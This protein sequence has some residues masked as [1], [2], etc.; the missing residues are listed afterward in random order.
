MITM[1]CMSSILT[2]T[3]IAV[4]GIPSV[5]ADYKAEP[6]EEQVYEADAV[7]IVSVVSRQ[8]STEK[9]R[10]QLL[11]LE[12]EDIEILECTCAVEDILGV[13]KIQLKKKQT[14]TILLKSPY[15]AQFEIDR[16]YALFLNK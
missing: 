5:R 9:D 10:R 11:Q 4:M 3:V 12:S 1:N 6:L 14:I 7:V 13:N 8:L 16:K 15:K 2:S